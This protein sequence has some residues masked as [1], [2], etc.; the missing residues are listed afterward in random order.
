MIETEQ[1]Q[2]TVYDQVRPVCL[3]RLALPGRLAADQGSA[4][5]DVAQQFGYDG[6]FVT[7]GE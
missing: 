5:H 2:D 1:M 4:Y 7:G 6:L 3:L